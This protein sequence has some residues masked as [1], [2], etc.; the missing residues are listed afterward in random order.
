VTALVQIT[1]DPFCHDWKRT[2]R[3]LTEARR[4]NFSVILAVDQRSCLECHKRAMEYDPIWFIPPYNSCGPVIEEIVHKA[5]DP[6]VLLVS[7]D[8][9]PSP[10]LW[11]FAQRPP[12]RMNWTVR[13]LTPIPDGRLYPP[14]EEIQIRLIHTP[15]W[16]W[17]GGISGYDDH[18][19]NVGASQLVLW[20]FATFAPRE[21]RESKLQNYQDGAK[22]DFTTPTEL[23]Q[24]D[25][26]TYGER[27]G[28]EDRPDM[29]VPMPDDLK[30]QYP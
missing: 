21:F 22:Q 23:S 18:G 11:A 15:T 9:E 26:A 16:H 29:I 13:M 30:A 27:H 17:V 10:K 25:W 14:G 4:R 1:R 5:S 3:V 8:E 6:M 7:D 28:W 2:S 12:I 20:H 24:T 19:G